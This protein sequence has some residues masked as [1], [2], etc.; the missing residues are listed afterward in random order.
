MCNF[1]VVQALHVAQH[2]R[3]AELNREQLDVSES[4][5][6]WDRE[7]AKVADQVNTAWCFFNNDF[8]G[9]SVV[10]SNRFKSLVGQP[11]HEPPAIPG[12][13]FG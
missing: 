10:T 11:V 3:F 1:P 13:L 9:Y 2:Q 4:L 12:G 6:W 5:N 8:S 7:I